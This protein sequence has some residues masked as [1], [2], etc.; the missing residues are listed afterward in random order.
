MR[1][2]GAEVI[3]VSTGTGTPQRMPALAAFREWTSAS[4]IRITA[5]ARA[6]CRFSVPDHR[7][8]FPVGH[9]SKEI[10]E[11]MLERG[12]QTPDVDGLC[13]R[14]LERHRRVLQLI[15]DEGACL[16]GCEVAGRGVNTAETAA[17]IIATGRLGIFHGMKSYFARTN[18]VRSHR[19]YSISA[20]WIIPGIGPETLTCTIS[21]AQSYVPVDGRRSGKPHSSIPAPYRGASSS[22]RSRA[23]S[24]IRDEARADYE[25][26][27]RPSVINISG[28]GDKDWRRSHATAAGTF[29]SD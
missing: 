11:Q 4:M 6:W 27:T 24:R 10:K 17:T 19:F 22:H 2:L 20:G 5:S 13:R 21:A 3:P 16:I 28:R 7:A 23:R 18:T 9:P 1:L 12:G 29:M 14:R 26:R 15:E 25:Y 8:R